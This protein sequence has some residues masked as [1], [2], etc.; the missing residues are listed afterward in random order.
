VSVT[1]GELT[2]DIDIDSGYGGETAETPYLESG[3][4][5]QEKHDAEQRRN[6]ELGARTASEGFHD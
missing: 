1:I 6:A 5:E 4:A 3:W 2:S